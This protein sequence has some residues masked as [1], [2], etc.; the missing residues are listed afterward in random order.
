MYKYF[1]FAI[2]ANVLAYFVNCSALL[3]PKVANYKWLLSLIGG[4]TI[5]YL[6]ISATQVGYSHVNKLWTLKLF[7]FAVSTT[8]FTVLTWAIMKEVPTWKHIAALTLA[9]G[10]LALNYK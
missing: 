2:C 8:I 4:S 9:F 7:G 5:T 6:Y 10:I 3:W 1:L